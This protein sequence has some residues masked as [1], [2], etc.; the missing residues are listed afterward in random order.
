MAYEPQPHGA[1]SVY[2]AKPPDKKKRFL[3]LILLALLLL[4]LLIAGLVLAN[5]DDDESASKPKTTATQASQNDEAT[6]GAQAP[7]G[8]GG[9][10]TVGGTS[11]LPPPSSLADYVGQEA[12]GKAVKVV[13]VE[14]QQGFWVG[15]SMDERV[16]V[17]W[18]GKAGVAEE[19]AALK[20]K[21]GDTVDLTA[22]VRPSPEQ[23]GRTLR[24][25]ADQE[26]IIKQQGAFLNATEV[27]R[28]S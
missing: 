14:G 15:T 4:A 19:G 2:G 20:P 21:V 18:G 26:D 7:A 11:I 17:E 28:A 6:G 9:E 10:L 1:R 5:S 25:P 16:Y 3:P 23:P 12:T 27:E 24:I 8:G 22:E 13:K